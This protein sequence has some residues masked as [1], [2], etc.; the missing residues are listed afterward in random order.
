M[1]SQKGKERKK[2]K[3]KN[4]H[5]RLLLFA[6]LIALSVILVYLPAFKNGILQW[7][8]NLYVTENRSISSLL[9][10]PAFFKSFFVGN[11]QPLTMITY[12]IIWHFSGAAPGLYHTVNILLHVL[13]SLLVFY[14]VNELLKD[15][16]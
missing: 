16:N 5:N 7:D 14:F 13:N 6:G 3:T 2:E 11:Y 12:S 9:N 1:K 15:I 10:I 8:D 4:P